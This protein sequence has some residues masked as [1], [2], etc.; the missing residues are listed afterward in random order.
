MNIEIIEAKKEDLPS[1][2][3]LYAVF[4]IDNGDVLL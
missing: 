4:D 2:M 1:I 3:Q